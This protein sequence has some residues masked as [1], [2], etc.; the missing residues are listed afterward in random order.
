MNDDGAIVVTQKG[1]V[2]PETFDFAY[3]DLKL[4]ASPR[5]LASPP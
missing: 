5:L 3:H 1:T 4:P 2:I